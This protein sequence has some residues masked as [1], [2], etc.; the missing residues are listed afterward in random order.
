MRSPPDWSC[1]A[2]CLANRRICAF[3]SSSSLY[4]A[5][6]EH[7]C[8]DS[9]SG[10]LT[11]RDSLDCLLWRA[12]RP[13]RL[14]YYCPSCQQAVR[15]FRRSESWSTLAVAASVTGILLV[16]VCGVHIYLD[17]KGKY[18]LQ[19]VVAVSTT[20]TPCYYEDLVEVYLLKLL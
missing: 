13:S 8:C 9:P 7:G 15:A 3:S 19:P 11:R 2:S 17:V 18:L 4:S 20:T 5:A 14:C 16:L 6:V 1:T 12:D 10:C